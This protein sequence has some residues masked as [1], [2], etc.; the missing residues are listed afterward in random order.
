MT[1]T[2]SVKQSIKRIKRVKTWHLVAVLLLM[3]FVS[4][5]F[6]RLNN[7]G[8]V[9]RR[10]AVIAADQ[11]GDDQAVENR[12][13]D[14]RQYVMKH[15]NTNG[16]S[17]YLAERYNRDKAN[18]VQQAVNANN[19]NKDVINKKVDDI[20]KPQYSGYNQGYVSCFAREYAKYAP[21]SDPIS[22]IKMPDPELYRADFASPLW[23]PDFAGFSVLACVVLIVVIIMRIISIIVLKI[24]LK[25]KY[26]NI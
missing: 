17:V 25:L 19:S 14:L 9:Q 7:I 23:S 6:L 8:M 10:E 2:R 15:M 24:I 12:L 26:Q 18:L 5:T 22:T 16:S 4:A 11:Q 1:N 20:C 21:G 3:L 13:Y